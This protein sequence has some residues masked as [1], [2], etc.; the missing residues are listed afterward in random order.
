MNKTT[1][2][3]TW[4]KI[5]VDYINGRGSMRTLAR[6]HNLNVD[7]VEQRGAKEGW[8]KLRDEFEANKLAAMLKPEP[9]PPAPVPAATP[10]QEILSPQWMEEKQAAYYVKGM[11]VLETAL[12]VIE[13]RLK[14]PEKLT[15]SDLAKLTGSIDRILEPTTRLLGIRDRRKDE[16]PK[17]K[18]APAEVEPLVVRFVKDESET[19]EQGQQSGETSNEVSNDKI[20]NE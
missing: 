14:T 9:P 18:S 8:K 3:E 6:K 10:T 7:T 12:T 5:R 19:Q 17:T 16:P 11:A 20:I 1:T 2:R 4:Q 15:N 13:G